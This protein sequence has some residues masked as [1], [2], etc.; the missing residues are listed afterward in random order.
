MAV[1]SRASQ[2][3]RARRP[4]VVRRR[5]A[6]LDASRHDRG[7]RRDV[8][9]AALLAEQRRRQ[10]DLH[11]VH[12]AGRQGPGEERRHQQHLQRI[13]GETTTGD[14]SSPPPVA[15]SVAS[16]RPTRPTAQ[17]QGRRHRLQDAD[18]Q[19]VLELGRPAAAVPAA[20]RLLRV[21]AAPRHGPGRQH[22]VGRQEP[23]QDLQ[24]RQ[25]V[26]HVRRHRRL[27]GRQAGD[28]R[29]R[30]LPAHARALPRDR[31]PRAEGHAAGRSSRH[32]Q[33]VVRP[34]RRRRGRR[35]LPVG[36]R[37]RL[38]GD[39]RGRRRQPRARP[40]P[41]GPQDG[42]GDHL[43]RR[44]R[45]D[46]PQ[47]RCRSRRRPRRA[48]ADAEPDA[49]R[50]GRLRDQRGHRHPGGHQP[51]RHP[52]PGAAAP[53]SLRPSDRGAAARDR[54]AP[55]H[56][57]RCTAATSGWAPTSISRSWPRPRPA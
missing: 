49:G 36:H 18:H 33:D 22:H 2:P 6:A 12:R 10:A 53:G 23:G 11:R 42:S 44:D 17:G 21:D 14:T 45:L 50:D 7:P 40:V 57:A 26:H 30:R 52:R 24:P 56:P 19:L 1:S 38:H 9:P 32:R 55:G 5:L 28:H 34:R 4:S 47:A 16:A 13:T 29:G 51:P 35:R 15:A 54:R 37:F 46:R 39:V 41:A 20:D 27:R 48:R 43:H 25:A 31:R 3:T 8:R